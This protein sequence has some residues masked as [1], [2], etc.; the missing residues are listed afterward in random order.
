MRVFKN[1]SNYSLLKRVLSLNNKTKSIDNHLVRAFIRVSIEIKKIA[2]NTKTIGID[3][4]N[5]ITL[6]TMGLHVIDKVIE[7]LSYRPTP[8]STLTFIYITDNYIP[9]TKLWPI[10]VL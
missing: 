9:N 8:I 6:K 1:N 3:I 5:V 2:G 10:P 4:D 7:F